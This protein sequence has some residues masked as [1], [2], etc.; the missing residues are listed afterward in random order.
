VELFLFAKVEF[1]GFFSFFNG[2]PKFRVFFV[3][4]LEIWL[5]DPIKLKGFSFFEFVE[6][7]FRNLIDDADVRF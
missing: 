2:H 3:C 7:D 1:I 6:Q 4:W 5:F